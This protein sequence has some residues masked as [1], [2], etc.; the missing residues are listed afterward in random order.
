MARIIIKPGKSNT[1]QRGSL[2][3][4]AIDGRREQRMHLRISEL[5]KD[6]ALTEGHLR[7]VID[8]ARA[9]FRAIIT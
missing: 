4:A 5:D 2:R 6:Y 3:L 8:A 7:K 9:K 1:V